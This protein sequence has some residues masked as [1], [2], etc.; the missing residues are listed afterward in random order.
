MD[1][2]K[3]KDSNVSTITADLY[4]CPCP[5]LNTEGIRTF[6]HILNFTQ[7]YDPLALN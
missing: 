3:I 6:N 7:T 5:G 1:F 2:R 4:N